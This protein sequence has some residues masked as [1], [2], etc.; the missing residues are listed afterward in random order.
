MVV[1]D[2]LVTQIVSVELQDSLAKDTLDGRTVLKPLVVTIDG[3]KDSGL[4]RS[5]SSKRILRQALFKLL[6]EYFGYE[7]TFGSHDLLLVI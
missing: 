5:V 1:E 4:E 3:G 6:Q 7:T 2:D